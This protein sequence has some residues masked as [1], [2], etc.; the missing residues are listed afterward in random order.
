MWQAC[1]ST[2]GPASRVAA[3]VTLGTGLGIDATPT[4]VINGVEVV[5]AVPES[6]LRAVIDQARA[7]AV[8][9]GIPRA[10][11]YDRAVLGM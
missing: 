8:A 10:E 4:F 11:Y 6:N 2:P 3:D 7:T 5:G 9:S 1:I